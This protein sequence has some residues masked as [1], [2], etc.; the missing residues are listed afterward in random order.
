MA[1]R[2]MWV[3]ILAELAG[4]LYV[5]HFAAFVGAALGTGTMRQL[6]LMTIR[7][8][9]DSGGGQR[10][11]CAALGGAGLGVAPLWIRHCRF[12]SNK[13]PAGILPEA[14]KSLFKTSFGCP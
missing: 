13:Q 3:S 10:I 7:A 12:L 9:R 4:F 6:A 1:S 8:L 14:G 5:E 2:A 11:M